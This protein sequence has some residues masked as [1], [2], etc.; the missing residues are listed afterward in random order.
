M[1]LVHKPTVVDAVLW[2]DSD[3][4]RQ[5]LR[6]LGYVADNGEFR[7]ENDGIDPRVL[8]VPTPEGVRPA[9]PGESWVIRGVK[10]EWYCIAND[11]KVAAYDE[12]SS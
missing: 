8:L 12:V 4:A 6:D 7:Y 1:K 9:L 11:V 10:G 3:D 5:Q 2:D